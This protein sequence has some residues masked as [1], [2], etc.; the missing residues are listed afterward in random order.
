[1]VLLLMEFLLFLLFAELP[2]LLI[3][4]FFLLAFFILFLL[5]FKFAA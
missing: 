5:E 1:M 2:Y 4:I 3:L